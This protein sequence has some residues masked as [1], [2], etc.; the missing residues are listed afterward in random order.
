MKHYYK[1]TDS[2]QFT[3]FNTQNNTLTHVFVSDISVSIKQL[4]IQEERQQDIVQQL[5]RNL[6]SCTEAEFNNAYNQ[7]L[8][9]LQIL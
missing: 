3:C 9:V 8:A 7:A 5:P 2:T 4:F 1:K 6:Q